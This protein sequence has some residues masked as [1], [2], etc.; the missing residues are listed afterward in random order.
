M[1]LRKVSWLLVLAALVWLG[2][3]LTPVY[4]FYA[5]R[6]E[7]PLP[8][9]GWQTLPSGDVPI[10][11]V[12]HNPA[13]ADAANEVAAEMARRVRAIGLPSYSASVLV[14]GE[15]VWSGAVGWSDLAHK[16][17]AT[18]ATIYRIGSTS[19]ALTATALARL[20]DRRV[21]DLDAPITHYLPD[22]PNPDWNNITPRM[23]A[24]HTAGIPHYKDN[25]EVVGLYRSIALSTKF[26]TAS[27]AAEVFDE[28]PLL[29][30]PGEDFEYS[31]LGFVL[32][33]A[34]ME[35]ATGKDFLSIVEEEVFTQAGTS[36]AQP[37]P[38]TSQPDDAFATF[39]YKDHERYRRWRAVDLSHR[40]P[41]GGFAATA[42]NL[43]RIGGLQFQDAYLSKETR[44]QFWAPQKLNNGE[45]N[46]Q[47]YALGWR[48]REWDIEGAGRV[49]NINHG[50]VS[51]GSQCWL[52]VIPD[53]AMSL[54]F[55][56]NTKTEEFHDFAMLYENLLGA[57][58]ST[59]R[60]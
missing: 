34:V 30:E 18:P 41:G 11:Q 9:F 52:I 21:I 46:S 60:K 22:L 39:Y 57:F 28:S 59:R 51:R 25:T 23:L 17:R 26:F 12:I 16:V 43:A 13:Y 15:V 3:V 4:G 8:P 49:R 27:A 45:V 1:T 32:L 20:V 10:T 55:C 37:S 24:S 42:E 7:L 40:L 58:V 19:K 29:Y 56:T 31:S 53:D 33:G 48:W 2:W 14:D 38:R 50:G 44:T 5:H 6:G 35:A 54:A 47:N 36:S